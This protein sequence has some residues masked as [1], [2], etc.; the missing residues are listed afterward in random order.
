[1]EYVP[2]ITGNLLCHLFESRILFND[3]GF[4]L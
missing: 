1:M 2:A 4:Y 3:N